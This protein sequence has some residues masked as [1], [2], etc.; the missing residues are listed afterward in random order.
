M[1]N[2]VGRSVNGWG[3]VQP[4]TPGLFDDSFE[5]TACSER[6]EIEQ[7]IKSRMVS[8]DLPMSEYGTSGLSIHSWFELIAVHTPLIS[9]CNGSVVQYVF[10]IK[11]HDKFTTN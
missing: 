1:Y 6:R 5:E 9:I 4:S 7:M 3:C 10:C 2:I 11:L 8:L